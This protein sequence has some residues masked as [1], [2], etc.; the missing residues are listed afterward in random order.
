MHHCTEILAHD[1]EVKMDRKELKEAR[2]GG[3]EKYNMSLIDGTLKQ[4]KAEIEEEQ[5]EAANSLE[6]MAAKL[7]SKSRMQGN[8]EGQF[9]AKSLR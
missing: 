7:R 2:L 3:I 6:R 8:L 5:D 1:N 9:K 4:K